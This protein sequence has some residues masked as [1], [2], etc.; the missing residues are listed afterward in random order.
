MKIAFITNICPHY[1]V[2]T[3]ETLARY[4]PVYFYF[5]SRGSEWYWQFK[6]GVSNGNFQ[7]EYLP[8]FNLGNSSISLWLPWKLWHGKFDIYIKCI[9]GRFALPVTYLI[10]RL[11]RKP[12][13][14]WTGLWYRIST[15]AHRLF[16][17][18][19]RHIYRHADA[20]VVYGEHVR[21]YLVG[22]GASGEKIF[23]AHHAVDNAV[24]H[25]QVTE[26][27]KMA[28]RQRLGISSEQKVILYLGRIEEVKG[29]SYLLEAFATIM[30]E[31]KV[32]ILAGTGSQQEGL[33]ELA[34]RLGIGRQV[35]FTGYVPSQEATAYYAIGDVFVLPS[36]TTKVVKEAWG[37]VIN[38]AFN[39][40]LPVI[41]TQAVGA[42]AGGLVKH[43]YNGLIVAERD[44]TALADAI[45]LIVDNPEVQRQYGDNALKTILPWDNEKM[46]LGFRQAIE[47]VLSKS[48]ESNS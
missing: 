7:H 23:I 33:R 15:P 37:L 9:N 29:I 45:R 18:L 10:A 20:I 27:E 2:K 32:L 8:G 35:L 38:E 43:E 12:F 44:P 31:E 40:R 14:L 36:V 46:V 13:I 4:Y 42:A 24:Y 21:N 1:R 19:T 25:R 11:K 28:L 39:Q 16:F 6:H 34:G 22:E 26:N 41:T 47:Y 17:P 48:P 5:Y 30:S 3:F